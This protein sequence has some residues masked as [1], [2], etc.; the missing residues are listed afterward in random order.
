[1]Q[2]YSFI[3][4]HTNVSKKRTIRKM[5]KRQFS[6]LIRSIF[7][8]CIRIFQNDGLLMKLKTQISPYNKLNIISLNQIFSIRENSRFMAN[9]DRICLQ[10]KR[11]S[12][13][14]GI[15]SEKKWDIP[16][17]RCLSF[18]SNQGGFEGKDRLLS[19]KT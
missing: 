9:Q 11:F 5:S 8:P 18:L 3:L 4:K 10:K 15:N 7:R 13:Q 6:P 12:A 17:K 16:G 2:K 14:E 19:G 1:M